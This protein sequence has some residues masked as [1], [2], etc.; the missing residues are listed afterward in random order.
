MKTIIR[1][2][3]IFPCIIHCDG[4]NNVKSESKQIISALDEVVI[5]FFA[6]RKLTPYLISSTN[7]FKDKY[8]VSDFTNELL[9][10]IFIKSEISVR[11]GKFEWLTKINEGR[12]RC[13]IFLIESFLG[14]LE[15][16]SAISPINFRFN[17]FYIIV[18][19]SGEIPE[20][21]DIFKLLWKIKIFNVNIMFE[22]SSDAILVKTFLPFTIGNCNDTRPV[23]INEFRNGTFVNG[24]KKFYPRKMKNLNGCPIR[25]ATSLVNESYFSVKP[26]PNGSFELSG[27]DFE[28]V[29][30]LSLALNF[31]INFTY[32][33]DKGH[34]FNND[35]GVGSMKELKEGRA[36]MIVGDYWLKANRLK[37]FDATT[38]YISGD[39]IFAIPP[40]RSFT[41]LDKLVLPLSVLSWTSVIAC[42][43]IGVVLIFLV[44][45]QSKVLQDFV[46][47]A[48]IRHP[49]LNMFTSFIGGSQ[50]FLPKTNFAR[51][52]LSMF[53]L[54][55]MII[56]TL[57]QGSFYWFMQTDRH[58]KEV[59]SIDEM[60]EQ[61]FKFYIF[62]DI[63]FDLIQDNAKIRER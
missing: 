39:M 27:R 22:G 16:Y 34:M 54:Y 3:L 50:H 8:I 13:L 7:D 45:R 30:L 10:R 47:G 35:T 41:S 59:Q 38:S 60:I 18:L 51:Y 4:I 21:E 58:K 53:L 37:F 40:G 36:D 26:F 52:L 33:G 15:I 5:K 6:I 14:F 20:V 49:Y 11:L 56:R 31:N 12:R 62:E 46:F 44:K 9:S 43:V 2:L 28:L 57:Y 24:V 61:D 23:L 32:M 1:F 17:G 63:L 29:K 48:G 25:V 55:S 42:S 19:T